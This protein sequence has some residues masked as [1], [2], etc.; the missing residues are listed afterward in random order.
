MTDQATTDYQALL[1]L[2][3]RGFVV[4]GVGSGI[5][6]AVCEALG[7][8]GASVLCVD[9]NEQAA[10]AAAQRCGGTAFTANAAVRAE[11]VDDV[12]LDLATENSAFVVGLVV[13][14]T[15]L[16]APVAPV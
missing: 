12:V 4:V 9:V 16:R 7:Q 8:V 15:A 2:D 6:G 14:G 10:Q 5:G 11:M 3:G 1:R 13:H